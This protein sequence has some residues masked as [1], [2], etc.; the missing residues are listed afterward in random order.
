VACSGAEPTASG[1][2]Y[3]GSFGGGLAAQSPYIYV[4]GGG[5]YFRPTPLTVSNS[6]VAFNSALYGG[7]ILVG[8]NYA[9][10]SLTS[11]II[12]SNV[13]TAYYDVFSFGPNTITGDHNIVMSSDVTLPGDTIAQ[14]PLL[15]PLAYNGGPTQTHALDPASPAIDAGSNPSNLD[16]DQRGSGFPRVVGAAPDIGAFEL[17][18]DRIF[19]DDF[20]TAEL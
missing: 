5:S 19:V 4:Y 10:T 7:G 3:G 14:D 20:D 2:N 13:D 8:Y 9:P 1:A 12:A 15:L 17:D 16:N 11:S 6:T 18:T